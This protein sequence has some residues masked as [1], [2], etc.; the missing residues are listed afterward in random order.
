MRLI[1]I[2]REAA[3][4]LSLE[5]PLSLFGASDEGDATVGKVKRAIARTC[6]HLAAKHD[7]QVIE[8]D[9]TFTSLAAEVQTGMIP[10]DFL[11]FVPDSFWDRT[12]KLPLHGPLNAQAW[13]R[14]K[15]FP[16]GAIV[17]NY[18]HQGN[19]ILTFPVP[20]AGHT[21]SFSY[22]SKNIGRNANGVELASFTADTDE[23]FWDEELMIQGTVMFMRRIDR[24]ESA[25]NEQEFNL[26]IAQR[27]R[28]TGGKKINMTNGGGPMSAQQRLD[29]MRSNAAIVTV[30]S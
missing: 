24:M 25:T 12:V 20:A 19:S 16:V 9:R 7:W 2:A 3:D 22:V 18:R 30:T 27:I 11:R 26:L 4:E 28:E 23:P 5:A 15:V 8:R 1:D 21:F 17:P 14:L 13:Q 29:A 6:R 10:S